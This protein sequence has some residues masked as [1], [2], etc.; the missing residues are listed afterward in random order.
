MK[1]HPNM[2]RKKE[3]FE[4]LQSCFCIPFQQVMSPIKATI[5][6]VQRAIC[7]VK[8][9]GLYPTRGQFFFVEGLEGLEC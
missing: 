6:L 5:L 8:L 9:A 3:T 4:A 2:S 1:Q 7:H